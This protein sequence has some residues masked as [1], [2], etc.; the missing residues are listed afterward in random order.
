M[1]GESFI[2]QNATVRSSDGRRERSV[3]SDQDAGMR[4]SDGERERWESKLSTCISPRKSGVGRERE[5]LKPDQRTTGC[6]AKLEKGIEFMNLD[7]NTT[8]FRSH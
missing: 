8:V 2:D 1:R 3:S 4:L 7:Q 5:K 6:K